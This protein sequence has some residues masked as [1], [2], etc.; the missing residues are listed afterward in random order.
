MHIEDSKKNIVSEFSV[1]G[2]DFGVNNLTKNNTF[3]TMLGGRISDIGMIEIGFSGA[4]TINGNAYKVSNINIP[5]SMMRAQFSNREY[6]T[7][8]ALVVFEQLIRCYVMDNHSEHPFGHIVIRHIELTKNE[9]DYYF[10]I[11]LCLEGA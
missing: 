1:N 8:H 10:Y 11:R 2:F 9:K 5:N 4:K 3:I 6:E 7:H